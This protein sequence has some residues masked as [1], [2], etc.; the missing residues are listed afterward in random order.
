M[1]VVHKL[2]TGLVNDVQGKV[3]RV[4]EATA[5]RHAVLR[6]RLI[7]TAEAAI[8]AGGLGEV[9]ARALAQQAGCAVGAIYTVFG[10]IDELILHVSARTL[11]DLDLHL[12]EA[13]SR[14][15]RARPEALLIVLAEAYL[16]YAIANRRRWDA[17]FGHRMATQRPAPKWFANLQAN[18]FAR[19][20]GPV[21]A[22]W[23]ALSKTGRTLLARTVFSAVHGAVALGLDQRVAAI[24]SKGLRA[25]LRLLVTILA[26]GLTQQPK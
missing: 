9:K 24:D 2:P 21:S 4:H 26:A 15:P 12:Q 20:E 1:N 18:L 25:Q 3:N 11:T 19:V 7:D 14:H 23:P 10:D 6:E 17:L 13:V 22:L 8:A 5:S 16:D